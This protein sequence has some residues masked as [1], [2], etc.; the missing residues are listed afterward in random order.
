MENVEQGLQT[1]SI[2]SKLNGKTKGKITDWVYVENEDITNNNVVKGIIYS[3]G[4]LS[5]GGQDVITDVNFTDDGEFII[6]TNHNDKGV[7]IDDIGVQNYV[8]MFNGY[9]TDT[10]DIEELM[11]CNYDE[12]EGNIVFTVADE[13]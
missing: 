13:F 12:E 6:K 1:Y 5:V 9:L 7:S 11:M 4:E 10:K 3:R 8:L 2:L